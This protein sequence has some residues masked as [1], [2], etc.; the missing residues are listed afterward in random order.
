[1]MN[2]F[3]KN[4]QQ[5]MNS[6]SEGKTSG[7]TLYSHNDEVKTRLQFLSSVYSNELSPLDFSKFFPNYS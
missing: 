7:V 5:Y 1:M 3:F 4:L 6:D 2:L